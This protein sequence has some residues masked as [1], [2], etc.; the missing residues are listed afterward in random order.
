MSEYSVDRKVVSKKV[1]VGLGFACF[2]LLMCL[3]G[4]ILVCTSTINDKDRQITELGQQLAN[5]SQQIALMNGQKE[6]LLGYVNDLGNSLN[7][8][9]STIWDD[10]IA[11]DLP[12]HT[13]IDAYYV[14]DYAGYVKV[15]VNMSTTFPITVEV[16]YSAY[17]VSYDKQ[18]TGL[19]TNATL[20]FSVLPAEINV[21]IINSETT[22]L[23]ATVHL[24][25]TL[26]Y[27]Y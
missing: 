27:Y 10:N 13:L 9:N 24:N 4:T 3:I 20:V 1:A 8:T 14:A 23:I 22:S 26:T 12:P 19:R 11:I 6:R 25:E 21:K 7:L 16:K 18:Q 17:G 2:I 15:E 5:S